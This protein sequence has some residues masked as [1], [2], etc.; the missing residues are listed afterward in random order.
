M[1]GNSTAVIRN[2]GIDTIITILPV[3]KSVVPQFALKGTAKVTFGRIYAA[4]LDVYYT[5][6]GNQTEYQRAGC[7][8]AAACPDAPFQYV[9]GQ[10][11]Q[12]G[13]NLTLQARF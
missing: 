9:F 3:G 11:N 4:L 8:T 12:L 10:F 6:D 1:A 5:Y 2:N 13:F 7:A